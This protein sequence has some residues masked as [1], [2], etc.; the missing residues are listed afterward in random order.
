MEFMRTFRLN[1]NFLIFSNFFSAYTTSFFL[2]L[3][4]WIWLDMYCQIFPIRCS[5]FL[6]AKY[7]IIMTYSNPILTNFLRKCSLLFIHYQPTKRIISINKPNF[8]NFCKFLI[9][10]LALIIIPF[11]KNVKASHSFRYNYVFLISFTI[12]ILA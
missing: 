9:T 2:V 1:L 11:Y 6:L 5:S 12:L 4:L 7:L 8:F 10:Y 3:F